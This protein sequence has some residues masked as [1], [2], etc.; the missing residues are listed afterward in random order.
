MDR[1]SIREKADQCVKCGLCLPHCPTYRLFRDEAESPRGRI[2]LLQGV[3][4]GQLVIDGRLLS[5]LDNC[6]S[7]G[8]C[9]GACPSGVEYG[10]MLDEARTELTAAR[11][12]RLLDLLTSKSLLDMA[13]GIGR[14]VGRFLPKSDRNLLSK[15]LALVPQQKPFSLGIR[16]YPALSEPRGQIQLFAG[17]V[18]R[19][20]DAPALEAVVALL[21]RQGFSVSVPPDQ[22]CCGAMH[23]HAGERAKADSL[24]E[25]NR[26]AFAGKADAVLVTSS[27]CGQQ[28]QRSLE[29]PVLEATAFLARHCRFPDLPPES[30]RDTAIYLP[31]SLDAMQQ[32][33]DVRN[34]F[35]AIGG[36]E[37]PELTGP[38][39]CGGAGMHMLTHPQMAQ[40]LAAPLVGK[41][42]ELGI[43]TLLTTNSGCSLHL[44]RSLAD[45]GL[46]VKVTHPL[47]WLQ[48][49][50]ETHP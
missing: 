3:A 36:A 39:C 5:H 23:A 41:V 19:H 28:L 27:G 44:A 26:K 30:F 47:E 33:G 43:T 17:C 8:R 6:L 1:H 2:A 11:H 14:G 18:G 22:G 21:T 42:R 32:A 7:C 10:A 46:S 49:Q 34:L 4:N 38:G 16:L 50:L 45:A 9:E 13:L 25:R 20:I 24:V 31:C 48:Q 12:G 40:E 29:T 35:G 37:L 15:L